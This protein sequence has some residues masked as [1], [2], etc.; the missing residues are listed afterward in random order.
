[1]SL[2]GFSKILS[3]SQKYFALVLKLTWTA[4]K[5][6]KY[7]VFS[8]Q[9]FPVFGLT[10]GKY[11]PEKTPYLE[12][13]H[14]VFVIIPAQLTFIICGLFN[15]INEPYFHTQ[16][17]R[18]K[19]PNT[20]FFLVRTFLYSDWIRRFGKSLHSVQIQKNTDQK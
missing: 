6:C 15:F 12:T 4:W 5:V 2:P 19:C 1:M 10:T 18:E 11:G 3:M 13:F 14:A 9:Y 16:T 20:E 7:K 8:D 17:L